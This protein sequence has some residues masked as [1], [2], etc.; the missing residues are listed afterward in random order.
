MEKKCRS[1]TELKEE[2]WIN[3]GDFLVDVTVYF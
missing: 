1:I 3:D 2:G